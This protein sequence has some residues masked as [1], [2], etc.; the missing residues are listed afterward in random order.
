MAKY[1]FKRVL[2]SVL[3]MLII[4]VIVLSLLRL[5]PIEGYF[6][7]YDKLSQ[8]QIDVKLRDLGLKDPLPVQLW[9]YIKQ[10]L[11]GDLGESNVFR[12][13][14]A[15]TEIVGEKIP[16]S[17]QLGLISLAIALALGLPLG[18]MM[19]RSTRTRWKLWDKFGT[20][21]IVV[22]QA[23]PAAA[24]HI[25][26]QFAGSQGSLH[27]P[28]LFKQGD[29][30]SYIL[31]I[32]SLAIGNIAYYAMWLR[33]YMVDESN[34]D[35]IRLAR[36]KG[37]PSGAISRRHM[38]RNAMVPLIQYIPNSILFTLMGS[39]Y[40]ESLYSIPGMGGLLVTVIK[41]QDNTMVVALVLIYA[42]ISILGLLFGDIL[43]AILDPRISFTKKEGA[44]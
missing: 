41:R 29:L 20:I 36:A 26:I 16:I 42:A 25:L 4:T 7:N 31:P 30:R 2:R 6:E 24:Y 5:M 40:V 23:V 3:T 27:L 15:I 44:R 13:G 37:L 21:F 38:F 43:M 11:H 10:L 22:V 17:L 1:I 12:K 14:V 8:T 33:R 34:K 18:I 32:F 28:M 39:L 19:A 35:Y 9:D